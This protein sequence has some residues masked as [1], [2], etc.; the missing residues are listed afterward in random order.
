MEGTEKKLWMEEDK[1][2]Q[3]LPRECL[4]CEILNHP[5]LMY[6][7]VSVKSGRSLIFNVTIMVTKLPRKSSLSI[8]EIICY[9]T[10]PWETECCMPNSSSL[11]IHPRVEEEEGIF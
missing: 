2:E 3:L 1:K 6:F 9:S 11:T 4:K 10:I 5:I 7:S 8:N